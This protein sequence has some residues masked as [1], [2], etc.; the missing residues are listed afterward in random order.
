M[1]GGNFGTVCI[2][3]GEGSLKTL[4]ARCGLL[5]CISPSI[6]SFEVGAVWTFFK[7]S[8]S[9]FSSIAWDVFDLSHFL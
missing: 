5:E 1:F 6:E 7:Q 3:L 9:Y 2:L 4:I 8:T